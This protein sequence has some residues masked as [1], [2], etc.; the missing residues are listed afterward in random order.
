MCG[1]P[2]AYRAD[3]DDGAHREEQDIGAGFFPASV[4]KQRL[5]DYKQG[6]C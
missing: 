2:K 3:D 5:S 4:L 1:Q 6:N